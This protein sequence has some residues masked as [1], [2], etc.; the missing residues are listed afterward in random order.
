M[1]IAVTYFVLSILNIKKSFK[2]DSILC[3]NALEELNEYNTSRPPAG[4]AEKRAEDIMNAF[5]NNK[6]CIILCSLGGV[7]SNQVLDLLKY[8]VIKKNAKAPKLAHLFLVNL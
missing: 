3:K 5:S 4:S 6:I 1:W 8:K 2:L 7:Y